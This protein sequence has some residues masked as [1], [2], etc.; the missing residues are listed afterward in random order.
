M[1]MEHPVCSNHETSALRS[2]E[3]YLPDLLRFY[4]RPTS[5]GTDGPTDRLTDRPTNKPT[6]RLGHKEVTLPIRE[7]IKQ[8][9]FN[10]LLWQRLQNT[11]I[12]KNCFKL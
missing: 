1:I 3:E 8:E 7:R 12:G 5:Q 4:D 9:T 6:D 2:M 10:T 11:N